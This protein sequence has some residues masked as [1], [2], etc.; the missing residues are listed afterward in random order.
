MWH[1]VPDVGEALH[2]AVGEQRAQ[3]SLLED[4]VVRTV[5]GQRGEVVEIVGRDE[6][7]ELSFG[8]RDGR[9][10]RG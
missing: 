2:V 3:E 5:H 7:V 1:G 4:G 8:R 6:E 9:G 10:W